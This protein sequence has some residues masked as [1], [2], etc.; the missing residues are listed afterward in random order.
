[1]YGT[2]VVLQRLLADAQ[3]E[4]YTEAIRPVYLFP[5]EIGQ[6]KMLSFVV[7]FGKVI[8][9]R[10]AAISHSVNDCSSFAKLLMV[11][12]CCD[13]ET[14]AQAMQDCLASFGV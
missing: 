4:S 5:A 8:S 9:D 12:Y 10:F 3:Q 14:M 7:E 1:M 13:R 11:G 6:S 2:L